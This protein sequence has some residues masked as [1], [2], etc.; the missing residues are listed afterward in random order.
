MIESIETKQSVK[1]DDWVNGRGD[2]VFQFMIPAFGSSNLS[3]KSVALPQFLPDHN[4]VSFYGYRDQ[5]LLETTRHEG[6]WAN[7]VATAVTRAAGLGYAV[8]GQSPRKVKDGRA[9]LARSW[10]GTFTG[11]IPF[12]SMHIR[13][14][15]LCGRAH[16][17]IVRESK[18]P[19]SRVVRLAHLNPYGS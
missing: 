8:E 16:V 17:E 15:I 12:I 19:S 14:Y 9:I 10:A 5:I 2:G 7:T 3:R 11:W 1:R 4:R 18:G 13:S 6:T